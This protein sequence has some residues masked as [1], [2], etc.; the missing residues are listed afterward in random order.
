MRFVL[1]LLFISSSALASDFTF[2]EQDKRMHFGVSAGLT[3]VGAHL[4]KTIGASKSESIIGA[5]LVTAIAGVIKELTDLRI[6]SGD[7]QGNLLGIGAGA[8]GA[9][10]S[11]EF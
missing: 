7:L 1:I 5:S 6:E 3:L 11:L 8:L 4:F 9:S 2:N 10:I